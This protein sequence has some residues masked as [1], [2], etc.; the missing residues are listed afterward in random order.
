MSEEKNINQ[1]IDDRPQSTEDNNPVSEPSTINEPPL[2]ENMEVH[3]H[4]HHVTHKKKWGEYLLEFLMLFLAVFLGFVA[5]NF[6]EKISIKEKAHHYLRNLVADLK[7]DSVRL[8]EDLYYQPLW[9]GHLDSALNISVKG[10]QNINTQDTFFY[11]FY[12]FYSY[13]FYF[14]QS[15]NTI[16]QLKAGG[17]NLIHDEKTIDSINAVYN[18]YKAVK[19]TSD[20][21][22]AAYW[23]AIRKAQEIMILPPPAPTLEEAASNKMSFNTEIF[24][25]VNKQDLQQLYNLLG[26]SKASLMSCMVIQRKYQERVNQLL[27]YLQTKYKTD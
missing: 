10:L 7:T 21:N 9:Y 27:A 24:T 8:K 19:F 20:Y 11:H 23:D 4:P 12:P 17:F 14:E 25:Q 16:A 18:Y 6:R 26:N 13:V 22:V 1:P 15:D 2:T 5:E 3:K